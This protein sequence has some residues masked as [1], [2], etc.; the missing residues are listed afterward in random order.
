MYTTAAAAGAN[1][2]FVQWPPQ[3]NWLMGVCTGPEQKLKEV[4]SA[5]PKEWLN[6]ILTSTAHYYLA[7]QREIFLNKKMEE[8]DNDISLFSKI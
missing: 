8:S 7:N 6:Q 4:W 2:K 3:H 5:H 1:Y